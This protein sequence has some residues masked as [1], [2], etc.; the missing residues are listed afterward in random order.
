MGKNFG[1]HNNPV[2]NNGRTQVTATQLSGR[3]DI[4]AANIS[5]HLKPKR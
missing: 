4:I 3:I 1:S 5:D 2:A